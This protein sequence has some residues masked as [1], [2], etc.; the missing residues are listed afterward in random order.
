MKM[1]DLLIGIAAFFLAT[2][3]GFTAHQTIQKN[4]NNYTTDLTLRVD[5]E[6]QTAST[7]F[8][9][10]YIEL[11][12]EDT[13]KAKFYF[14]FNDTRNIQR[15]KGLKQDSTLQTTTKIRSFG[16]KTYFLYLRYQDNPNQ[17][18]DGYI[19]LYKIEQA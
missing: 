16:N 4:Q 6:K 14:K 9:G 13:E 10:N 5:A 2:A 12:Y 1:Q 18:Q 15:I 19:E 3:I 17:T 8:D 11:R 7:K